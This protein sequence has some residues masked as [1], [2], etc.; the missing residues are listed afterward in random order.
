MTPH[1]KAVML[2]TLS[3]EFIRGLYHLKEQR[4]ELLR[5]LVGDPD[6]ESACE[7]L[8]ELDFGGVDSPKLESC[9]GVACELEAMLSVWQTEADNPAAYQCCCKTSH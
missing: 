2:E 9:S 8:H 5:L 4:A 6:A 7:A 3:R 1:E